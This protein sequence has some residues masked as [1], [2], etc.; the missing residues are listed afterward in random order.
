MVTVDLRDQG[1]ESVAS[2]D[3]AKHFGE[4]DGCVTVSRT[5]HVGQGDELAAPGL[6]ARGSGGN[7]GVGL[8]RLFGI[9][10]SGG[11]TTRRKG[12]KKK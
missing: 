9:V 2:A 3:H 10:Q 12:K 11:D 6:I 4:S 5:G 8:V 7:E 1:V